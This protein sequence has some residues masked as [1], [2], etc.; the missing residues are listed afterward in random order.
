MRKTIIATGLAALAIAAFVAATTAAGPNAGTPSNGTTGGYGNGW[1][2]ME[3][4]GRAYGT[5]QGSRS[6]C[7]MGPGTYANPAATNQPTTGSSPA[8]S[9]S[10]TTR[11]GQTNG[12]TGSTSAGQSSWHGSADCRDHGRSGGTSQN[13]WMHP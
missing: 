8:G 12:A 10:A 7:G 11:S 13:G 4:M 5:T 1:H 6:W 9:P 2:D 3:C